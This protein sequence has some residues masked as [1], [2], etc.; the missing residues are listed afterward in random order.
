MDPGSRF[1]E[2]G[3]LVAWDSY[4]GQAPSA[5]IVT[6]VGKI[7]GRPTVVVANDATVKAGAWWPET[8]AKILRAQEIA[9][10]NRIPIVYLVDSAGVNLPLQDGIF[11]GQYGAARIFYYNS[12][13][14]RKL[15]IPQIAAVMGPCIAGGAYLPALSDV[16][17]MVKGT[18]FMGLGGPNLVRGATG[19]E[20]DAE[21][22][23]GAG[24]HTRTSGVAHYAADNSGHP[25]AVNPSVPLV[26][27][28]LRRKFGPVVTYEQSPSAHFKME[29]GFDVL[30]VARGQYTPQSYR[31]FI[32][33]HVSKPLLERTFQKVYGLEM[34]DLF[35][36]V[37]LALG[38][39]RRAV[40][41]IIPEMTKVAWQVKAGDIE[42][43]VPGITRHKFIYAMRRSA[44]EKEWGKQ[45][46]KPG[47]LA[48]FLAIVFRF[49]PKV[50]ILRALSFKPP[51]PEAEKMFLESYETTVELYRQALAQIRGGR[52]ELKNLDFDT[53]RPTRA[54]EYELCD[55]TYGDLVLKLVERK[56]ESV[57]PALRADILRFFGDPN[58]PFKTKK[59][60]KK[61]P[62]IVGALGDL[63]GKN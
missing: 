55:E 25:M 42:K 20:A 36:S 29:F 13:M 8:I 7:E 53:G 9:I 5:G 1:F 45:Y 15:R 4:D 47:I 40:S 18:S 41:T 61:W 31:D 14:R 48:R 19:E 54:G 26:Y 62:R 22:L 16:I 32:G 52:L 58:A 56:F 46:E 49:F 11:P 24:L 2:V 50:G 57:S 44:Y 17:V 3:L 51:T 34:K 37:D 27:P 59:D 39:Y 33:F 38:T 21:T 6:G 43:A 23:G 10:R 12:L 30:Q 28:K 60:K 35:A 63:R